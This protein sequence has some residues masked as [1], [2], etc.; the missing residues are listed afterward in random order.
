MLLIEF[1]F[2]PDFRL[3]YTPS[4]HGIDRNSDVLKA[5]VQIIILTADEIPDV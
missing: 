5:A 4:E 2:P 1:G 3:E